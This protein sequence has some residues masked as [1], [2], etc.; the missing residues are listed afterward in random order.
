MGSKSSIKS[1]INTVRCYLKKEET[2]ETSVFAPADNPG[3]TEIFTSP[4]TGIQ[5]VLIPAGEFEMGAPSEE[6]DRSDSESPIH[7]VTIQNSFYLGRS[8]VTQKQWKKIMENNPSHFKGE[9]RPVE[10]ISWG[11]TQQFIARLNELEGTD[12]YRL[13]SEAEW[14]YACRAGTQTRCFLGEDGSK[15]DEYAWHIENSGGKTHAAGLKKPNPWG[16]YDMHGNV[17]EW[18]QDKWHENYTGAPPDG[19]AWEEGNSS[20]RVSRGCSWLCNTGFCR[21]A[22]RFKREPE[23]CFANLGFRLLR[24]L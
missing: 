12:K 3:N 4:S 19:T 23:S 6:K 16:L 18:V 2:Q 9:D 5:F 10:M 21:S 14:E 13:P 20:N 8:A 22:G 7:K 24:E 15:L 17:W 1:Y 11:D